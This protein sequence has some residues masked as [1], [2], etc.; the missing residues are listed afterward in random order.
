[1]WR[2]AYDRTCGAGDPAVPLV[3]FSPGPG[4]HRRRRGVDRPPGLAC[5][6]D[7]APS[8]EMP[9]ADQPGCRRG[10]LLLGPPAADAFSQRP[11]PLLCL[12]RRTAQGFAQQVVDLALEYHANA[13]TAVLQAIDQRGAE[14]STFGGVRA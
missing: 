9:L 4:F 1:M 12:A 5:L 8:A 3:R 2:G 14:Q 10:D 13:Q 11:D 7:Y 6:Q